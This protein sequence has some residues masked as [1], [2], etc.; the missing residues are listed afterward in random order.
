ME[1]KYQKLKARLQEINDLNSVNA[2]LNWDQSTYMPPGGAAARGRQQAVIGRLA[3]EKF[4]DKKIGKLLDKLEPWA[5]TLPYDSE[6]ASLIRVTRR[7]YDQSVKVPAEL[8]GALTE[9]ATTT[10]QV[11]AQ[12]R[13]ANDFAKVRPYLE[14]TLDYSRQVA[15]C[16]PGYD[17]I[18]DPLI[19]FSDEGMKAESV[20]AV[21]ADLREQ[22]VP[23]VQAITAQEPADDSC[24]HASYPEDEQLAFGWQIAQDYGYDTNRGRQ[25]KTHHPF[26]TKFSLGDVRITTRTKENDLSE[27]L[28]STLHETGHALYEQG[29]DMSLEATP[30]AGGTSS[31]V[32]ESQSRLWENLVGRS[33]G[34]WEHYYPKLQAAFPE[35]LKEVSLDTFYAAINKVQRS[36]I[37]TDAD[38]VTYNLHVMIRFDLELALLEG[39]L[40]VKDLP[41]VWNGRYQSDLGIQP[42][43]DVNGVLQDVHWYGGMIGGAFQGYTLGNIMSALFYN[44]ALKAHP[45]IPNQI[46]QGEFGTLHSW[47]K[48]NIYTYGSKF[49]ANELIERVT[50]GPLTIDPYIAYLKQKFGALYT[51]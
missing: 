38:E 5:E 9:H 50:G 44:E 11:W 25:D 18:A 34:F 36:L 17:H 29:I 42:P 24:L 39:S 46:R 28:F 7:Q 20:R 37:R 26:M 14:K 6:E 22:L 21:F 16:F 45:D 51:L 40:E 19:D 47:L 3:H 35:Q 33:H 1:K 8:I 15:N 13:P 41:E 2:L 4:I 32:H 23:L 48:N 49:T 12:A 30:L 43:S 31:G 27:A 10:Y